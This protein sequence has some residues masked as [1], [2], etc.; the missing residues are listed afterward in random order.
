MISPTTNLKLSE[1][2]RSA[3]ATGHRPKDLPGSCYKRTD[4]YFNNLM[5]VAYVM[6]KHLIVEKEVDTVYLGGAQGWDTITFFAALKL[7]EEYPHLRLV[8]AIPFEEQVLGWLP[9][10]VAEE[11]RKLDKEIMS[12]GPIE[13]SKVWALDNIGKFGSDSALLY[14][15]M[16]ENADEV[17]YVD[18]VVG[19]Q[20][21]T[22]PVG[23]YHVA[24]LNIRNRFMVDHGKYGMAL[25]SGDYVEGGFVG[26]EGGTLNCLKYSNGLSSS[27]LMYNP[28]TKSLKGVRI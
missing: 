25:Y 14:V 10:S 12:V 4:S 18:S 1:Y 22:V 28:F 19:Y 17:V 8:L 6:L 26:K 27:V 13:W 9:K 11:F 16:V 7:K 3:F 23:S 21:K 20:M 15:D 5:N 2:S 24:K